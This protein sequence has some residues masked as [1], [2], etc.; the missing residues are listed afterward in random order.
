MHYIRYGA[1]IIIL[2]GKERIVYLLE[3]GLRDE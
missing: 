1:G 2:L 3:G